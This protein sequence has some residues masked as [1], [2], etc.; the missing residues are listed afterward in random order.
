MGS[1]V[2]KAFQDPVG[3]LAGKAFGKK[4]FSSIDLGGQILGQYDDLY[5]PENV[6]APESAAVIE[7]GAYEQ[8]DRIRRI[9]RKA[10]GQAS[11]I[12]TSSTAEPYTGA[13]ARLL[14]G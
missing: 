2:K 5:K 12:R 8:R 14:G 10:Q 11:T 3:R 9:A 7:A 6:P 1:S 13:P 4:T